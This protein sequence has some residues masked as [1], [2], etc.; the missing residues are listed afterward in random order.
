MRL[1]M[2]IETIT[3]NF[4]F[5]YLENL[6]STDLVWIQD[7]SELLD[8]EYLTNHSGK[9]EISPIVKTLLEN[10]AYLEE[11]DLILLSKM[12][13]NK[14]KNKWKRLYDALVLTD[15]NAIENYISNENEK[16]TTNSKISTN[17]E[18]KDGFYGFNGSTSSPFG[19]SMEVTTTEGKA[20]DNVA[21]REFTRKGNT[22]S[23]TPQEMLEKEIE[24]RKHSFLEIVYNDVDE[25]LTANYYV[26]ED[27]EL[28][29]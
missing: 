27:G 28:Y 16:V 8:F 9:K 29:D 2:T 5:H 23:S 1:K 25:L 6:Y 3:S 12:L 11:N 17:R 7:N 22:G 21:E 14:C 18:N 26:I 19:D 13:Y 24:L 15:Y 4:I 20:S 10:K